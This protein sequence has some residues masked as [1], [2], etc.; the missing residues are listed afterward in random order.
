[1]ALKA[2][3]PNSGKRFFLVPVKAK[4]VST[5]FQVQHAFK[6][7]DALLPRGLQAWLTDSAH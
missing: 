7:I 3:I 5:S 2:L 6:K 1:L 4:D